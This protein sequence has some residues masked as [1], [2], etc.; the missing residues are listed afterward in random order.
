MNEPDRLIDGLTDPRLL[1]WAAE[2]NQDMCVKALV[3]RA[4]QTGRLP[5]NV[6]DINWPEYIRLSAYAR[7]NKE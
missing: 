1:D 3:M 2:D 6:I 7:N 4:A 5:V